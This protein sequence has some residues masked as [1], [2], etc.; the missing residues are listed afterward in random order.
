MMA[1]SDT[2][3]LLYSRSCPYLGDCIVHSSAENPRKSLGH[4]LA[5]YL[6]YFRNKVFQ[7]LLNFPLL[8]L[9]VELPAPSQIV[10]HLLE[11]LDCHCLIVLR[12]LR[13]GLR[14]VFDRVVHLGSDFWLSRGVWLERPTQ[15]VL[16]DCPLHAAER[17]PVP[18]SPQ[19]LLVLLPSNRSLSERP[20][21]LGH[22]EE[23][24]PEESEL[25][26]HTQILLFRSDLV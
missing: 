25:A 11:Y 17:C 21:S 22:D 7:A 14:L 18:E 1:D 26:R 9:L 6:V 3:H 23:W 2:L 24:V 20:E 5:S 19:L 4:K 12:L 8:C 15:F 10:L 16:F 13:G